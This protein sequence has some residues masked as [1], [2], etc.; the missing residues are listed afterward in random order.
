[1]PDCRRSHPLRAPD[2]DFGKAYR[3]GTIGRAVTVRYPQRIRL[4]PPLIEYLQR[5]HDNATW[6]FELAIAGLYTDGY[7][8]GASP[9][10]RFERDFFEDDRLTH[11]MDLSTDSWEYA[12]PFINFVCGP[13]LGRL[14]K[15]PS[16]LVWVGQPPV[17]EQGPW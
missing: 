3:H 14:P 7:E 1:M 12:P 4:L 16:D 17:S 9:W 2:S 6:V 13:A 10:D 8:L 5:K 15:Y 11:L